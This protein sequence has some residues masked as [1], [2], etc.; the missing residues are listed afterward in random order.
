MVRVL[1]TERQAKE[2]KC[3]YPAKVGK[4]QDTEE[5]IVLEGSL[6]VALEI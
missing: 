4:G 6:P 2:D 3:G 5:N 1:E